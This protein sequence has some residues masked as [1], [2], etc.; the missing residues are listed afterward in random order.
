MA[1]AHL[2]ADLSLNER[3]LLTGD[4]RYSAARTP[5]SDTFEGFD[6]IDLSGTAATIGISVRY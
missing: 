3:F 2:G 6:R 5:L 1:Y 4:L